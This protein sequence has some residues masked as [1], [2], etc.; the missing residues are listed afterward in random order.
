MFKFCIGVTV[1]TIIIV[2]IM[3]FNRYSIENFNIPSVSS[4]ED[5]SAGA[6]ELYGWGYTPIKKKHKKK[7]RKCP[8]C[9]NTYVDEIDLCDLCGDDNKDCRYADITKNV[10]IDK[11]VLKSSVPPCPDMTEYA[12]KTQLPP[13]HFNKDEWIRK[14]EI[15]PCPNVNLDDYIKKSDLES[16]N[17]RQCPKCPLCPVAPLAPSCKNNSLDLRDV[18]KNSWKPKL[19]EMNEAFTTEPMIG[20]FRF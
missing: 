13:S 10:D 17:G 6:S 3:L 9:E 5:V 18:Y 8:S 16:S 12:K 11:Y 20:K 7:S 15:P 4:A 19:S 2:L 1:L 14:S